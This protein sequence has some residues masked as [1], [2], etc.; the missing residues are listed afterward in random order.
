MLKTG[1]NQEIEAL[2]PTKS[3]RI[4][5]AKEIDNPAIYD[6]FF[7]LPSTIKDNT[8]LRL[9]VIGP[10]SRALLISPVNRKISRPTG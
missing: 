8:N 1:G 7:Y 6:D 5:S 2:W 9:K 3:Y 4:I 10:S